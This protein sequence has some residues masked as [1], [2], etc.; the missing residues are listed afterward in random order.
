[1]SDQKSLSQPEAIERH[2]GR[3]GRFFLSWVILC[4]V[5]TLIGSQLVAAGKLCQAA[6]GLDLTTS[7][8]LVTVAVVL[9]SMV[10][11]YFAVVLTD[12]AQFVM[13]T[14]GLLILAIACGLWGNNVSGFWQALAQ[15]KTTDFWNPF[16]NLGEHLSMLVTF[17]LAWSI[18]PEMWQ[19]MSSTPNRTMA[20]RA[21]LIATLCLV[22][23]FILVAWIGLL[24]SQ[25]APGPG[26]NV[27]LTLAMRLP[28][29]LL[30]SLVIL[31]VMAAI[32]S[33]MDSSLNV[34]SLTVA[35]D[36]YQG[37]VRPGASERE[38]LWVSRLAT[39]LVPLPAVAIALHYQDII[40]VLWISADIY[41]CTMFFPVVGLLYCKQPGRWSGVLAMVLGGLAITVSA[42][43]QYHWIDLPFAWPGWPYSTLVGVTFSGLGFLAG[44]LWE[45][46]TTAASPL[47][48]LAS[49]EA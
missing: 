3:L 41:A 49:P 14:L 10:G 16:H 27:L 21:A 36:L 31:G 24:S 26:D 46:R 35:R 7:T 44:W 37:F 48:A 12:I 42:A 33:T 39:V 19:R 17:V 5:T 9:Y 4:A 1:V 45:R 15:P 20:F 43:N 29:P 34:G 32:T 23:L 2:Y 25:L 22:G 13:F 47:P 38:L 28:H 18:A 30:A 8:A 40:Q 6:F 11:G